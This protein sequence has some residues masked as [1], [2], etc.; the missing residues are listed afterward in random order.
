MGTQGKQIPLLFLS[1]LATIYFLL[2]FWVPFVALC[3][4]YSQAM[5]SISVFC[6]FFF[7]RMETFLAQ[8]L[9]WG[10]GGGYYLFIPCCEWH[11]QEFDSARPAQPHMVVIILVFHIYTERV[12]FLAASTWFWFWSSVRLH[13]SFLLIDFHCLRL[14]ELIALFG[15]TTVV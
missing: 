9:A 4:S 10:H 7:P 1:P 15:S 13:F 12:Q 11:L 2:H 5:D 14:T 3:T 6:F 8:L